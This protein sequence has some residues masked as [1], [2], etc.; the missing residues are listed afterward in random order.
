MFNKTTSNIQQDDDPEDGFGTEEEQK[1][2]KIILFIILSGNPS[3]LGKTKYLFIA[4]SLDGISD[5][6]LYRRALIASIK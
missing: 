1:L 2:Q 5:I 6:D 4:D 3:S